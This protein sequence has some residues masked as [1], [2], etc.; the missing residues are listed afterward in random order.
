[1]AG[2]RGVAGGGLR[3]QWGRG[4]GAGVGDVIDDA[5]DPLRG[6]SAAEMA[7]VAGLAAP[8][9]AGSGL[10]DRLGGAGGIGRRWERGIGGILIESES[11]FVDE[12]LELGDPP[13]RGVEFGAQPGTLAA[14][15]IRGSLWYAHG[16]G[17]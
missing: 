6:Q 14:S 16:L 11:Q 13:Q 2:G 8:P 15:G 12:G 17:G 1:V 7:G 5:L 3:G 9:A 4:G 10:D